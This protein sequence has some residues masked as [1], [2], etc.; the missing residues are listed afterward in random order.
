MASVPMV[1]LLLT[2]CEARNAD[3]RER[4]RQ[5]N[6][7]LISMDTLRSDHLGCYGYEKDTS[8]ALDVL[9][10]DAVV[11]EEAI[12]QAS[13]TLHSHASM[14]TSLLPHH[15]QATWSAKTRIPQDAL[16]LAEVLQGAGYRTAAFTGGGQMDRVF[17][18]DQGFDFFD[19]P[20]APHFAGT[21][22]EGIDW[23]E[24][25][26]ESPFFLFLHSYEV[27]HPYTPR[28]D[29]MALFDHGYSGPLPDEISLELINQINN[30]EILFDETRDLEHV[31]SAY[32]AEVRSADDGLANLVRYL[33]E[34]GL[35]DETLIVFTSDHGEE[36]GEHGKIG[37]HSHTLFDELLRV[38]LVIKFQG[39]AHA[40]DRVVYQVRSIDIPPTVVSA[41]GIPIPEVFSGIDL[42]SLLAKEQVEELVAISRLDRPPDQRGTTSARVIGWKLIEEDLFDLSYDPGETWYAHP[43]GQ[44]IEAAEHLRVELEQALASRQPYP[45]EVVA[46]AES[47]VD[48]LRALG[49]IQ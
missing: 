38:P 32:D 10:E 22:Q 11:F 21:V 14:L 19:Q 26:D 17:G 7:I 1:G 29:Y 37:L 8:P 33:Q 3:R 40:G 47:T 24:Q 4:E 20:L 23:L 41:V 34:E 6:V 2:A 18:L 43:M 25:G 28:A 15:H 35:Y 44:G 49:Y 12:A 9:C 42:R 39:S 13:S 16:T 36:F 27:H 46:P 30:A 45:T 31:L 5:P 48:E